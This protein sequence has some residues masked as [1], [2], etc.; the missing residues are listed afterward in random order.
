[1]P[2]LLAFGGRSA[3]GNARNHGHQPENEGFKKF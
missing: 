3:T 1:M 2:D